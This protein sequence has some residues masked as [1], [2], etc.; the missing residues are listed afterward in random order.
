MLNHKK[1]VFISGL[2]RSGTSV[3]HRELS[4][5]HQCSGFRNTGVPEDE[6]QHLQTVF[7]NAAFYGGPGEFAFNADS[8]LDEKSGIISEANR[9]KLIKEWSKH[10]DLTKAVLLEKSPPNLIR[11]RFLQAMFPGA[12]F[13]TVVRHPVAVAYATQKFSKTSI[14]NLI[15]HWSRAHAIYLE[16]RKHLENHLTFSYEHMVESTVD[17]FDAISRFLGVAIAYQGTLGNRNGKYFAKWAHED[18]RKL[19]ERHNAIVKSIGFCLTDLSRY[20]DFI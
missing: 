5:C 18:K 20:S 1:I 11:T 4:A 19:Q 3:L 2:H 17:V 15:N 10:W 12:Y 7:P 8:Y 6:G 9:S 16:D 13:I 14:S